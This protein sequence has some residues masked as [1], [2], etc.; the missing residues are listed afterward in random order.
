MKLVVWGIC[1]LLFHS[2]VFVSCTKEEKPPTMEKLVAQAYANIK[3]ERSV[4]L[5]NKKR[6]LYYDSISKTNPPNKFLYEGKNAYELLNAGETKEAI[7]TLKS[8]LEGLD[9]KS[10]EYGTYAPGLKQVLALAYMRLGEQENCIVNHNNRSCIVPIEEEGVHSI[11]E[12]SSRA[13]EIYEELLLENPKDYSSRWL[14]NIAYMTLGRYPDEVPP[15]WLVPESAFDSG[16]SIERFLDRA[17]SLGI[18]VTGLAGGVCI[19]DFDNDG[20][21]DIITSSWGPEGNL[22]FFQNNGKDGFLERTKKALLSKIPGGLNMVHADYDNDGNTDILV[23]RGAWFENGKLP[24]SLLRNNGNGTFTDVTIESGILSFNA[25]QTATWSD[26][27]NDGWLDLF[28]G[29]E[30]NLKNPVNCELYLNNKKGGFTDITI[31][32]GLGSKLIGWVKGCAFGDINNDGWN[33]LYLSFY[34]KANKLFVNK[35]VGP[36]ELP[37]FE[38]IS[39]TA[40][41]ERPIKS[42]PTWFWDYN[43]DG[44][45]DIFVSGYPVGEGSSSSAVVFT[46]YMNIKRGGNPK[47]YRNKGDNTFE[48]VS[49]QLGLQDAIFTMGCNF[50]D[51]DNDGYEDFYLGTGDPDLMSIYPNRMFK[52]FQGEKFLDITTT[53]GFG[54]I[55]KGHGIGFGDLDN[56]GDQDIYMVLG[57][58]HDGDVF[59]NALF[60]NPVGNKNNWITIKLIGMQSNRSAIGARVVLQTKNK[61]SKE[62]KY[63]RTVTTGSSFGSSSLQLEIGLLDAIEISKLEIHWPNREQSKSSFFGIPINQRI[64]I[65]EGQ[66]R[67]QELKYGTVSFDTGDHHKEHRI[68]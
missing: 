33:D 29:N 21:L 24:N 50:G 54:H 36:D 32:A 5:F 13:I 64:E 53:G 9:E 26:I 59:Q 2:I 31:A 20:F 46:N 42:F 28:I 19:E 10:K 4:Y 37:Q 18:D 38:D 15:Q 6:A 11:E 48:E 49:R 22:H 60:E 61:D 1:A 45:L 63:Y 57:G 12:G 56:D 7:R 55:Q 14:I 39:K 44:W 30:S 16:E 3:V 51:L 68:N 35:G 47:I 67:W 34:N 41:I 27:N 23:L 62:K 52:N 65:R 66:D 43:N 40:G 8:V 25:T 58:A 17:P